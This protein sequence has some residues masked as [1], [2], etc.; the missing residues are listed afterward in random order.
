MVKVIEDKCIGCNA[1]IRNCPVPTA[2]RY[3]G[4]VVHVNSSDCIQCGECIKHCQHGARDYVDDTERLMND[5]HS[6]NI[7]L[8]VAPAI[9]TAMDG[10]WRHVL[11]W[12][13]TQGVR[14]VYD[15]SFG[16]D[17]CTYMHLEY[18]KRNPSAKIISQPCAAIVNYA[19]K[20]KPELLPKL[21]PIQSPMLCTAIYIKKYLHSTDTLVGLSPCIAKEDEFANTGVIAYNVTFRKLAEY[22]KAHN[23]S[24]SSGYSE[25]EWSHCRGFDGGFY[26]IPGGLKEC[27]HVHA[28]NLPV[29]TSEGV[30]KV[31]GDF[32]KYL[33][34]PAGGL[35][36]V[37]D[38]LSCEFGCNSGAGA[39]QDFGQFESFAIMNNVFS[40]AEKQAARK[41]FHKKEFSQLRLEDFCRSYKN[42]RVRVPVSESELNSVYASMGKN[43]DAERHIDCHACGY[44]SC[45]DM[46]MAIAQ[47]CNVPENCMVYAKHAAQRLSD[48]VQA[49]RSELTQMVSEI[50][51]ALASLQDKVMPI[52]ENT[53]ANQLKNDDATRQMEKL[54]GEISEI[55]GNIEGISEAVK[56]IGEDIR[57]YEEILSGIADIASQT[58][59]LAINASIEA[60]RA[61]VYGKGF[62]IVA[63]EVRKLAQKSNEIVAQA[64]V[65]TESMLNSNKSIVSAADSISNNAADTHESAKLTTDS[66]S[67]INEGARGISANVQ[68]ITAIIEELNATVSVMSIDSASSSASLSKPISVSAP[69]PAIPASKPKPVT[70]VLKP[71]S[72]IPASKPEPVTPVS[73]T[74]SAAEMKP[75]A[76]ANPSPRVSA[77]QDSKPAPVP[78]MSAAPSSKPKRIVLDDD[79]KY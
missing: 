76:K 37:Y 69:K 60:A 62:A 21:S 14:E 46:A 1:C 12:L 41:R 22:I 63:D 77:A 78:A 56:G 61:G 75:A 4:N 40:Y 68:E 57:N 16:A 32:D 59:I 11:Q 70:P 34:A 38:V 51:A 67:E 72:A 48:E 43:T 10:K 2:N 44:K 55:L 35:P 58:N 23:V 64:K 54:D 39:R 79:D 73:K 45:R 18:I 3:D 27:L 65:Y 15:T 31:Y 36:A 28:P 66:L 20:H 53:E 8:V 13:K 47:G 42:R 24:L 7:S 50:K 25:F 26:P 17:I 6:K 52:A 71:E 49:E 74:E 33:A 19:E 9:K 5:I 29:A 30:Q